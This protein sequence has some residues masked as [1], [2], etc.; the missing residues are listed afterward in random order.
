[1]AITIQEF[2][3]YSREQREAL[4]ELHL[5]NHPSLKYV[6]G[7][8][9]EA[10]AQALG[11]CQQLQQINLSGH[12]IGKLRENEF[13]ALINAL[14]QLQQLQQ[15][16]FALNSLNCLQED[17]LLILQNGLSHCLKLQQL[18]LNDNHLA[19][20]EFTAAARIGVLGKILA[21]CLELRE[22]NLG[23][24]QLELLRTETSQILGNDL[25][26]CQKLEYLDLS[27]TQLRDLPTSR[28]QG[29][30]SWLIKLK[31]LKKLNL[32]YTRVQFLEGEKLQ[33]LGNIFMQ[34][35]T[36]E[37]IDLGVDL[38]KCSPNQL[39]TLCTV[40]SHI[41]HLRQIKI[42]TIPD[43]DD[44]LS[45]LNKEQEALNDVCREK[46]YNRV[47][48]IATASSALIGGHIPPEVRTPMLL[49]AFPQMT[50]TELEKID[51]SVERVIS[52][53]LH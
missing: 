6:R 16:D 28:L 48:E 13:Q 23:S 22:L 41:P 10:F 36:L 52:R 9:F 19:H 27:G 21:N 1:M 43:Y 47:K 32:F 4:L 15:V 35:K 7:E 5:A 25:S 17:N 26:Q 45:H 53:R 50:R 49:I 29:L 46:H 40:F 20:P 38:I 51:R 14:A 11:E 39:Q 44:M 12:D 2:L 31:N 34:C 37:R 30:G 33:I 18:F 3:Q 42:T 8:Q 24:N